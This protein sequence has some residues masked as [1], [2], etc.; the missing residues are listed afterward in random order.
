MPRR[1]ACCCVRMSWKWCC[2]R[3]WPCFSWP[4]PCASACCSAIALGS[5][6]AV[7]FGAAVN[8][9]L[10]FRLVP[11]R[12]VVVRRM[13]ESLRAVEVVLRRR[14]R[15]IPLVA[16]RAP[17]VATDLLAVEHGDG[18]VDENQE[19]AER[20]QRRARRRRHIE[21]LELGRVRP[22]AARH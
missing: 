16:A 6:V 21:R 13:I 4:C 22:I 9:G 17:R 1:A 19:E 3:G 8:F 14:R 2:W 12:I 20:E 18:D 7:N 5:L 10:H 11:F 15:R